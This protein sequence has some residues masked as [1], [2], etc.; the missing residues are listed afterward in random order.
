MKSIDI[1]EEIMEKNNEKD[2]RFKSK[3]L[4]NRSQSSFRSQSKGQNREGIQSRNRSQSINNDRTGDKNEINEQ[5]KG[6]HKKIDD[7]IELIKKF[8]KT[9]FIEE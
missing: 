4:Y 5:K 9:N 1:I 6:I 7:L 3:S 2:R 8:V